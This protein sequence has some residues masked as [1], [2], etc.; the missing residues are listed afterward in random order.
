MS[1]LTVAV[2]RLIFRCS[3]ILLCH[4]I[5]IQFLTSMQRLNTQL[6]TVKG[7]Q[8][9]R[10]GMPQSWNK[11]TTSSTFCLGLMKQLMV[12]SQ[13]IPRMAGT[14]THANHMAE[15]DGRT[16][17]R[18]SLHSKLNKIRQLD[19]MQSCSVLFSVKSC[20]AMHD[21]AMKWEGKAVQA[22]LQDKAKQK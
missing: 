17:K 7:T 9:L 19:A 12:T 21:R 10:P 22:N 1:F 2:K 4:I 13:D 6:S 20:G 5:S 3:A 8:G 11:S 14:Q 15:Q 18:L 16:S